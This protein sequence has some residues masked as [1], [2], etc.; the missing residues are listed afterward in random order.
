MKSRERSSSFSLSNMYRMVFR[1]PLPLERETSAFIISNMADVLM[2]FLLLWYGSRGV[3]PT[4]FYESNPIA[5]YFFVRW[6]MA[7][8]VFFK[9]VIVAFVCVIS[10]II[11][12]QQVETAR[13]L[14]NVATA[15][16]AAV[17]IY[18]LVLLVRNF[19]F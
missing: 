11:A 14:L 10:Q 12:R 18:S 9:F 19:A 15:I 1:D 13:R 7:G 17:V 4:Q 8:M 16:T 2:T 6:N 3:T 5:A